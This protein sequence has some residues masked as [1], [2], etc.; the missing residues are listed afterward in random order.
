MIGVSRHTP[1]FRAGVRHELC[2]LADLQATS[3]LVRHV[4]P[5]VVIHAQ[6]LSDVDQCEREPQL[7]HE[8][9]VQTLEH[10]CRALHDLQPVLVAMSTDYVF[11]G[12]KGRPYQESD[13]PHPL[14][15]YGRTKLAAEQRVLHTPYG[16]VVRLSTLF[17]PGRMN[18]CET[19]AQRMR[20]GE[21]VEAF[22]DQTT[23]PTYAPD[24][25]EGIQALVEAL[26]ARRRN[27]LP[28][29]YHL[30]NTGGCTR[31]EFARHVARLLGAKLS[32]VQAIP[33]S[34]QRRPALRP[35]Y[36]ALA[37]QHAAAVIGRV[38]RPWHAAVQAYVIQQGWLNELAAKT[39]GHASPL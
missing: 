38:L 27:E 19:I 31:L 20:R 10:L 39:P 30:T 13:Q 17:G 37:S 15:V 5:E 26:T 7:A 1:P 11:D 21:P 25:A 35:A 36:S 8:Q 28:R 32:L 3:Q 2:D 16:Y 29:L 18:F 9:N 34:A 14:S 33:M 6:V 22:E 24:L 12:T 23:S 4:R